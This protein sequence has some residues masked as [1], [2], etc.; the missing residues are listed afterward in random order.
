MYQSKFKLENI[1]NRLSKC[2]ESISSI[3]NPKPP[4]LPKHAEEYLN[5]IIGNKN[6][7]FLRISVDWFNEKFDC[8]S[9]D[10]CWMFMILLSN[11]L[12]DIYKDL[13]VDLVMLSFTS[14]FGNRNISIEDNRKN[15]N[16]GMPIINLLLV[17]NLTLHSLT[18]NLKKWNRKKY[19]NLIKIE[20]TFIGYSS[21]DKFKI[22][23]YEHQNLYLLK[24][25]PN[26]VV[27]RWYSKNELF[28]DFFNDIFNIRVNNRIKKIINCRY[29]IS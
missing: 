13:D 17:S 11:E 26:K 16:Y 29:V 3:R 22:I 28:I 25:I 23:I 9:I 14:C 2:T 20:E 4:V 1:L 8:M 27:S 10:E 19:L 21:Y 5:F 7:I 24:M 15:I 6:V 12:F 18:K